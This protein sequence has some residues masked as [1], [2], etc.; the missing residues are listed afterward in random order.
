MGAMILTS[1]FLDLDFAE[2]VSEMLDR[3]AKGERVAI[4]R[5][6]KEIAII[7]PLESSR[8]SMPQPGATSS[9]ED[10]SMFDEL[11]QNVRE[12]REW[13]NSVRSERETP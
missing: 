6:G 9:P 11:E 12:H 4:H 3:V 2:H 13:A 10:E 5:D 8:P 1:H 7:V